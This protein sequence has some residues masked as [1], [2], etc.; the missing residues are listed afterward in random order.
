M[1]K[2]EK[3]NSS[4]VCFFFFKK[5]GGNEFHQPLTNAPSTAATAANPQIEARPAATDDNLTPVARSLFLLVHT[6]MTWHLFYLA[7]FCHLSFCGRCRKNFFSFYFF[8]LPH[9]FHK[10]LNFPSRGGDSPHEKKDVKN[11]FL[12]LLLLTSSLPAR[13]FFVKS[14][15]GTTY[16]RWKRYLTRFP[17]PE[18]RKKSLFFSSR[19]SQN[20]LTR[21]LLDDMA[22][23]RPLPAM[24]ALVRH[25]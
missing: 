2:K 15:Q 3:R 11:F 21:R 14:P 13:V 18:W 1:K 6:M 19:L 9:F 24:C 16:P 8:F 7:H 17:L 12:S 23:L 5:Y 25:C 20:V 4:T 10:S 22:L